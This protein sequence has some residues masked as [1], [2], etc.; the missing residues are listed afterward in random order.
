MTPSIITAARVSGSICSGPAEMEYLA[1][2]IWLAQ[3]ILYLT[4]T[5]TPARARTRA[6]AED[7]S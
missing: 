4:H 3:L 6:Y 5:H 2:I 7:R 1:D